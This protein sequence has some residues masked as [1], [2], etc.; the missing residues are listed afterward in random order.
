M[1][2]F[3]VDHNNSFTSTSN[4][5]ATFF[6]VGK[7]GCELFVHHFETVAGFLPS[8]FASQLFVLFFSARTTFNLFISSIFKI[9]A[10]NAKLIILFLKTMKLTVYFN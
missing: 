3:L 7:S 1:I 8:S 4:N 10:F 5:S 2:Y 6:K 9:I